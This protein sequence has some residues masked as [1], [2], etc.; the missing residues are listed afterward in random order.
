MA[1]T[2]SWLEECLR[3]HASG[4]ILCPSLPSGGRHQRERTAMADK[5]LRQHVFIGYTIGPDRT[6]F[7]VDQ[8][9]PTVTSRPSRQ[10]W[11]GWVGA[12]YDDLHGMTPFKATQ[13]LFQWLCDALEREGPAPALPEAPEAPDGAYGGERFPQPELPLGG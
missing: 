1:E 9:H 5:V 3:W 12:G 2:V 10:L 11:T 8:A 7:T 4:A 6:V 13:E